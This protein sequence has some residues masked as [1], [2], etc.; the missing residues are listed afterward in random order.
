MGVIKYVLQSPVFVQLN[1]LTKHLSSQIEKACC[2]PDS[3]FSKFLLSS[4]R[5]L[6]ANVFLCRHSGRLVVRRLRDKYL[7]SHLNV[8]T[9]SRLFVTQKVLLGGSLISF[10]QDK[11]TD[12]EVLTTLKGFSV[13]ADSY[14]SC[15][16]S[17]L[18]IENIASKEDSNSLVVEDLTQ[19]ELC[20][21]WDP[22]L[23]LMIREL[24]ET[25]LRRI[26]MFIRPTV[27]LVSSDDP[28]VSFHDADSPVN[29]FSNEDYFIASLFS[30]LTN[31]NIQPDGTSF[32]DDSWELIYDRPGMH[33]W[34]RPLNILQIN[35]ERNSSKSSNK[36]EYRVCGQFNDIS[37]SSFLEVQ[38]NLD[39]RRRWDDK[40]VELH[41]LTPHDRHSNDFDIIRW[42]VRFPFPM[43][44][45]EYIYLRRWWMQP[46]DKFCM[47][48][49]NSLASHKKNPSQSVIVPQNNTTVNNIS[50]KRYAYV[51]SRC[52]ADFKEQCVQSLNAS[53]TRPLNKSA[54]WLS[55]KRCNLVQVHEYHSEMLI[56]SH[57][58]FNQNGLN[59]YLI[60]YDD[61]CLPI[62]GSPMKLFSVKAIEEFMAKLHK[63]AVHLCNEGL[64]VGIYPIIYNNNN[65]DNRKKVDP[66]PI[67]VN[68]SFTKDKPFNGRKLKSYFFTDPRPSE[69][70]NYIDSTS[71]ALS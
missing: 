9:D 45:R 13:N 15:E 29:E 63:A 25:Y 20:K 19:N 35:G 54:S 18:V 67:V 70:N 48:I 16:S 31:L 21:S 38:L 2:Q 53:S 17:P 6:L 7:S 50:T 10:A 62:S 36:Y 14:N 4:H 12:E 22:P 68:E 44:N 42:V 40:I 37:A 39:Y 26:S 47:Q 5:T 27:E 65:N 60:Y 34:R 49:E 1:S 28:C 43:V 23:T 59:Y 3:T 64:P 61:P 55:T 58:E 41:C 52:S 51:I 57:G 33:I 56:E 46:V 8:K 11:I 69:P 24:R 71:A 32:V 30:L 66:N